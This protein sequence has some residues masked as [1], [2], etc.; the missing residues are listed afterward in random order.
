META[1]HVGETLQGRHPK[2]GTRAFIARRSLQSA[3]DAATVSAAAELDISVYYRSSSIRLD[4]DRAQSTVG[5]LLTRRGIDVAPRLRVEDGA[6]EVML[7][8]E[9]PTTWLRLV[10][11]ESIPISASSRAEPF[12][13]N[14]GTRR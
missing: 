5:R 7:A 9:T 4:A 1:G 13:Q 14:L 6:V 3:A 2:Y 10:G 11:I 8:S 12:P